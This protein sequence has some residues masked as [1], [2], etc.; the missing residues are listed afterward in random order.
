MSVERRVSPSVNMELFNK[1]INSFFSAAVANLALFYFS[2]FTQFI[3]ISSRDL[4]SYSVMV[5]TLNVAKYSTVDNKC[6]IKQ[7]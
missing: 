5:A 2:I 6:K 7:R 3:M 4:C 1:H